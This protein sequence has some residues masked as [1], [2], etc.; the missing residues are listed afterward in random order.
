MSAHCKTVVASYPDGTSGSQKEAS[1]DDYTSMQLRL[2]AA[3]GAPAAAAIWGT[4]GVINVR[5]LSQTCLFSQDN[6]QGVLFQ[7]WDW[8]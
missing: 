1:A 2:E 8:S 7:V 5:I 3:E 6:I 4:S